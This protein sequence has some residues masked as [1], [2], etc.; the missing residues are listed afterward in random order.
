MVI[1][2]YLKET[3]DQPEEENQTLSIE[4]CY[5]QWNMCKIYTYI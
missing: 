3:N 1:F 4:K 2:V 5:R